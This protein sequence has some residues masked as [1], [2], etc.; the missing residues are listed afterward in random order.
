[1]IRSIFPNGFLAVVSLT[2]REGRANPEVAAIGD[3]SRRE[4]NV[5]SLLRT[6]GSK[7]EK[8]KNGNDTAVSVPNNH[9]APGADNIT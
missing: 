3:G 1:M 8:D 9:R 6:Y 5:D 2:R 4:Q 7:D